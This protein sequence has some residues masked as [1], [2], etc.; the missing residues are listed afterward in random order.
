MLSTPSPKPDYDAEHTAFCESRSS[1]FCYVPANPTH[2][3]TLDSHADTSDVDVKLPLVVLGD[4]GSG[5]SALLSSWSAAR[6]RRGLAKDEFLFMHY[7]GCSPRSM[8]LH[9][10]LFRLESA[11][12]SHFNLRKME[13]PKTEEKLRWS[14]NRFLTAAS[15]KH[16]PAKI[17]IVIDGVDLIQGE[18][19]QQGQLHWLPTDIPPCVRFILSTVEFSALPTPAN[20]T[21]GAVRH[22]HRTFT[23]LKRRKCPILKLD[24]LGVEVRHGI[25]D[26]FTRNFTQRFEL[27]ETQAFKIVTA[28]P[29]SQPLFLRT[30][31]YALQLGVE[32]GDASID[33]QL[34]VYLAADS[35][36]A[37]ISQILDQCARYVEGSE[38]HLANGGPQAKTQSILGATLSVIY[39]SR[40]GLTDDEIWGAVTQMLGFE[41]NGSQKDIL[42]RILQDFCMTVNGSRMFTHAAVE[43]AVYDK[44]ITSPEHNVKLH[45]MMARYFNQQAPS[46]RKLQCQVWHL[47]VSGSWNKLKSVLVDVDNF[48]LWWSETN[49]TEF[50]NLWAS[51]TNYAARGKE[52]VRS[53]VTGQF[54]EKRMRYNQVP[55]PYCDV[56]EEYTKAIEE[57]RNKHRVDS[58]ELICKAVMDIAEFFLEF[59]MLGHEN[60]ADV[61]D[62][63]H[64]E[65]PNDDMKALGVPFLAQEDGGL[66]V[67]VKPMIETLPRDEKGN[68]M[69]DTG[70]GGD[71][72]PLA[73]N[74]DMPMCSTYFFRRWMWI[75]FPL[76]S[77]ANCGQKFNKGI[78][79]AAD[80][81]ELK[82]GVTQKE[83][84]RRIKA[85]AAAEK[86]K[87][88]LTGDADDQSSR[89]VRTA[90]MSSMAP[91]PPGAPVEEFAATKL[92]EIGGKSGYSRR[93]KKSRT[94]PRVPRKIAE[95]TSAKD[96]IMGLAEREEKKIMNEISELREEYD[97]LVQQT[98]MLRLVKERIDTDLTTMLNMEFEA[99]DGITRKAKLE[100]EIILVDE[101]YVFEKQ[102]NGNYRAIIKMCLRHP[103]EALALIDELEGK[104]TA[105][106]ALIDTIKGLL[107]EE[108]YENVA[109]ANYYNSMKKATSESMS[110]HHKMIKN[111]LQQQHN[112]DEAGKTESDRPRCG[113]AASTGYGGGASGFGM[114]AANGLST[115]G[116]LSVPQTAESD[117]GGM[118]TEEEV[119]KAYKYAEVEKTLEQNTGYGDVQ[120][121]LERFLSQPNFDQQLKELRR[122]NE[123]RIK[124]LKEDLSATNKELGRV[125]TTISG[126]SGQ[127]TKSKHEALTTAQ[128]QLKRCKE[129]ADGSEML[130]RNVRTGLE[131]I[132]STVG[133][134]HPHPDTS[135]HEIMNQ[136]DSVLEILMDEKDKSS[137][138]TLAESHA[139]ENNKGTRRFSVLPATEANNRPPELDAAL[140]AYQESKSKL[141]A[142]MYGHQPDG[143]EKK[144]DQANPLPAD[145][146]FGELL[147]NRKTIKKQQERALKAHQKKMKSMEVTVVVPA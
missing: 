122:V 58:D 129:K 102:L 115:R 109:Q 86:N 3:T 82:F 69:V 141:A 142:R 12:Q 31:L 15:K 42:R 132:A 99:T 104:L 27:N 48:N 19:A 2:F 110:L 49:R 108:L 7:A 136:I 46:D 81:K 52:P 56:V 101:K 32:M 135:V 87:G 143:E 91:A 34:E 85:R 77:L 113:S 130:Q 37:L 105:D 11:L 28:R 95:T 103:A 8:Q 65:I 107:R 131:N 116:V 5:K 63:I 51:L 59:A 18:N 6:Q 146:E 39:V 64:P 93:G 20:H 125:Q 74:D 90:S 10:M 9:H 134:P 117:E 17:V 4:R 14:L 54:R 120:A 127:E 128:T 50:I 29:A 83:Q 124:V 23:E 121:F 55:R 114:T 44:Y 1:K 62:Y 43:N 76:I 53:L 147:D 70:P 144:L 106:T 123:E 140:A 96:E 61:P 25:I 57:F 36:D 22:L 80:N 73:A 137:Q 35:P 40:C 88:M 112:L 94:V 45:Q 71:E 138:K 24:A 47:E 133:I 33:D 111:R 92:P 126:T 66:S 75:Q 97:N 41:L 98:G 118:L 16:F 21:A 26:V 13:V 89:L 72:V 84:A 100:E 30:V 68:V 67:L 119:E 79:R 78:Q 139:E 145:A 60:I 38:G